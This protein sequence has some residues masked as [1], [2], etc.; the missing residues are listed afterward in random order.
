MYIE[1]FSL[2]K[3]HNGLGWQRNFDSFPRAMVMLAWMSNGS[4][5]QPPDHVVY[6][7]TICHSEAWND[8]MHYYTVQYPRCSPSDSYLF[9]DCGSAPYAYLLFISWN[10][11]R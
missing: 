8:Y 10:V 3:W 11:I 7:D 1:V 6:T 2:T 5:K 4:V 9:T